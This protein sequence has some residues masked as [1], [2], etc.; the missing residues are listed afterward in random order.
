[1]SVTQVESTF[2]SRG[3]KNGNFPRFNLT[4]NRSGVFSGSMLGRGARRYV[5]VPTHTPYLNKVRASHRTWGKPFS[6][7]R[8]NDEQRPRVAPQPVASGSLR[9]RLPQP[10]TPAGRQAGPPA[11]APSAAGASLGLQDTKE[12]AAE[13]PRTEQTRGIRRRLGAGVAGVTWLP[14]ARWRGCPAAALVG[15]D[16]ESLRRKGSGE[17][18]RPRDRIPSLSRRQL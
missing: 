14:A 10:F 18:Y 5:Q 7:R 13:G 12:R 17:V 11:L 6:G 4:R 1:M 15:M 16:R 3:H 9:H 8:E 2:K